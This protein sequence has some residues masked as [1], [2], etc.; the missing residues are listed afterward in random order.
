[1]RFI[2]HPTSRAPSAALAL[3][4]LAAGSGAALAQMPD[5]ISAPMIELSGSMTAAARLCGDL[6]QA[7]AQEA[8]QEQRKAALE[9]GVDGKAFDQGF[10]AAQAKTEAR[11]AAMSP[12]EQTKSCNE[13]RQF[14]E[15][16]GKA[17]P[18]KK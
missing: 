4:C 17:L 9:R 12:A 18:S 5:A 10:Q 11:F 8:R 15:Q 6:S 3:A 13:L 2:F 14:G 7:K 1:M 16:A